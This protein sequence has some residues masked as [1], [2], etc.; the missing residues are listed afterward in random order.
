MAIARE[1]AQEP[2]LFTYEEV[3]KMVQAGILTE[4]DR[5]E[6]IEGELIQMSPIGDLHLG[7]VDWLVKFFILALGD[8]AIV[9]T[10]SDLRLS[11]RS[12]PMPDL[13][14][15]RPDASFYRHRSPQLE[16]VLL[17]IEVA[18][19]SVVYDT[20]FKARLYAQHGIPE[21][22]VVDLNAQSILVHTGPAESGYRRVSTFSGEDE[23]APKA[24]PDLAVSVQQVLG[25]QSH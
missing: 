22:W 10:Q 5:V 18:D 4:D 19:T 13:V 9:R 3:L 12:G 16:D 24:F 20:G 2:R 14:L 8:R 6:L 25:L 17:V 21:Y 15:L 1:T 7:C 23:V 11:S